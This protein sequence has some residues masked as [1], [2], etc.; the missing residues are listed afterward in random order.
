M[1]D[2]HQLPGGGGGGGA[3]ESVDG[4]IGVVDLSDTYVAQNA[5]GAPDGV[6][7]LDEDGVLAADQTPEWVYL[8]IR[9][10]TYGFGSVV[11]AIANGVTE[12]IMVSLA[13]GYRLYTIQTP[14]GPARVRLYTTAAARTADLARPIG[15]DPDPDAGVILDYV[16][17]DD[18]TH[19]LSP[20]VDGVLLEAEL[21]TSIPAAITN[22]GATE[23]IS[24]GFTYLPTEPYQSGD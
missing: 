8:A 1:S 11:D 22:L 13:P 10:R 2:F 21:S 19:S 9:E 24:V 4:Q 12:E 15:T 5:L 23:A 18:D 7:T 16:T 3:V 20:L 17:E 6:A 14:S